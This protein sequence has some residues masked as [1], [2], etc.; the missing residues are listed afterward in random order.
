MRQVIV[1]GQIVEGYYLDKNGDI[2]SNKSGD[3]KEKS[4]EPGRE[5]YSNPYPR[6]SLMIDKKAK[7]LNMHRVVCETFHKKPLPNIL[8]EEQWSNVPSTERSIILEHIQHADRYQV[9]HI[10]HNRD[11]YHPSN[12]EWVT[13]SENQQKYQEHKKKN[14]TWVLMDILK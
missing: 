14:L 8:T 1:R 9:N 6:V 12:L 13:V 2:Y 7:T 11:N 5:K 10:D 3:M 4:V